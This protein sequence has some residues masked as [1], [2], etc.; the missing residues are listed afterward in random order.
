MNLIKKNKLLPK[1]IKNIIIVKDNT[2][3][4]LT[5]Y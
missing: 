2:I 5:K 4:Y 1:N 3:I